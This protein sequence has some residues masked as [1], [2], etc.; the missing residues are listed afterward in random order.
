[1][2]STI[3]CFCLLTCGKLAFKYVVKLAAYLWRNS[4][5]CPDRIE[6]VC[7][8]CYKYPFVLRFQ[9]PH[10]LLTSPFQLPKVFNKQ[11]VLEL[12]QLVVA[13]PPHTLIWW[14]PI[15]SGTTIGG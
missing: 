10:P 3:T 7:A 5:I 14:I 9:V 13:E 4:V 8:C 15:E 2:T 11:W 6:R 12:L 1:M